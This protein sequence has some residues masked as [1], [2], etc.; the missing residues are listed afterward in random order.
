MN[1]LK[2][3]L[4]SLLLIAAMVMTLVTP[5]IAAENSGS[6]LRKISATPV[7]DQ[8]N[9][10]VI[11]QVDEA[12]EE[13]PQYEDTDIV[14]VSIVLEDDATLQ[15]GFSSINV[16][17][18]EQAQLY[19]TELEREQKTVLSVIEH[20]VLGNRPLDVVWNLTLAANLISANVEYGMIDKI[21]AVSGVKEV[22]LENRYEPMVVSGG[23]EA[24]DPAMATSNLMSG[25]VEAWTNGYTGA[26]SRIA[27]ID[28]GIDL[29]HQSFASAAFD[30][31]LSVNAAA[32]GMTEEAYLEYLDLLDQAEV[33]AVLDQLNV[34]VSAEYTY[35]GTKIPFA[36]NY[37]DENYRVTHDYDDNGE[38]G[39]HVAGIAAAGSYIKQNGEFVDA[40]E[41]V[42][43][44]GVAP[45]AQLLIMKVF[46]E[47][48]GAYDSDYMAAI[49]DAIILGADSVNLSLGSGG[50][51]FSFNRTYQNL[52]A[53]LQET[54]TVVSMSAGNSYS[55]PEHTD[56]GS[57]YVEDVSFDMSGS[58]GSYS[59]ALAV[60]SVDSTSYNSDG[61]YTPPAY[62]TMSDFSSW[63]THGS[64]ELK[65]E[66]TAPGGDIYSVDGI[67]GDGKQYETM[68]GTSMAAPQVAGMAAV[69]AEYIRDN[70]LNETTGL[71]TRQLATSLLMSTAMPLVEKYSE[72]YYSLL[73]QGSGMAVV[74]DAV[75]AD[76]YIM[77]G[78]DAT[79]YA[80]DGK[81][82]AEL[83]EDA[84]KTGVY[85]FSFTINNLSDV[86]K[87]Y[88]LRADLFT[89]AIYREYLDYDT[90][91]LSAEVV[92]TVDGV[93]YVPAVEAFNCDLNEDGVTDAADAKVIL[94]AVLDGT[95]AEL[96]SIADVN[97][98]GTVD[99]YDAHLILANLISGTVVLE[100]NA[101]VEVN[102]TATLTDAQKAELDASYPNGAYV[103]GFIFVESADGADVDHSIP[104]LAFYGSW[105]DASM[106]GV[107]YSDTLYGDEREPY[108]GS[109]LNNNLVVKNGVG[110]S[111]LVTGNP[112]M[113]E[114]SYPEGRIAI[115]SE[116]LMTQYKLSLIRNAVAMRLQ[117]TDAEGTE[118]YNSGI[119]TYVS[120]AYYYVNGGAWRNTDHTY[121]LNLTP[122]AIGAEE[123]DVIKVA[124]T[125]VPEYYALGQ[126]MTNE[127]MDKL[128]AEVMGKGAVLSTT[129]TVDNTAPDITGVWLD[130]E[131][132]ELVVECSDNNYIAVVALTSR[133]GSEIYTMDLPEQTEAGKTITHRIA[134]NGVSGSSECLLMVG[135]YAQNEET[136]KLVLDL[137]AGGGSGEGDTPAIPADASVYA[138]STTDNAWHSIDFTSLTSNGFKVGGKVA[139]SSIVVDAA[140][141]VD[142]YIFVVDA[143]NT[144]YVAKQSAPNNLTVVADLAA[145]TD[146]K[147]MAFN[148]A[149]NQMYVLGSDNTVYTM[150]LYTGE[151]TKQF[152]VSILLPGKSS[153][154][155]SCF[156]LYGMTI[157]TEG[158]FIMANHGGDGYEFAN[159]YFKFAPE[160]IVDGAVTDLNPVMYAPYSWSTPS[161]NYVSGY[162]DN[163]I[164]LTYDHANDRLYY[165]SW[166]RYNLNT[167]CILNLDGSSVGSYSAKTAGDYASQSVSAMYSLNTATGIIQPSQEAVFLRLSMAEKKMTPGDTAKLSY[168]IGP[169]N[170]GN[171]A[172]TWTSSDESVAA[173]ENGVVTAVA[174]GSATITATTVAA[175]NLTATCQILV[176]EPDPLPENVNL[177][178]LIYGADSQT[179]WST[180]GTADSENWQTVYG[181]SNYYYGGVLLDNAILVHD[182]SA[183]YAVDPD[184]FE[185]TYLTGISSSYYWNDG[186]AAPAVDGYF[187]VVVVPHMDGT[188][189][190]L[191]DAYEGTVSFFDLSAT[192]TADPMAN[193][194]LYAADT[195][196]GYPA[197]RYY[198]LT[199]G[200]NIY[201]FVVMAGEEEY[202]VAYTLISESGLEQAGVSA[203]LDGPSSSMIYDEE[204]GYLFLTSYVDA[205]VAY[206][207]AIWPATGTV[208]NLG[209]FGE[210]V[211]P[212]NSL[213]SYVGI[214]ELTLRVKESDVTIYEGD[215][216]ATK[217][218]VLP[219][220]L[221][222]SVTCVSSDT[223]VVTV[224]NN[225]VLTGVAPGT[226]TITV[227]TNETDA[228]GA[229]TATINVTVL[230]TLEENFKVNGFVETTMDRWYWSTLDASDLSSYEILHESGARVIAG[231]VH[232]EKLYVNDGTVSWFWGII[233]IGYAL[234]ID[235]KNDWDINAGAMMDYGYLPADLASLPDLNVTYVDENGE[236]VTVVAPGTALHSTAS[237]PLILM[238]FE[239]GSA[240]G[241]D[242]AEDLGGNLGG[243]AYIGKVTL[244]DEAGVE[245]EA[246]SYYFLTDNGLLYN[247]YIYATY[248][249]E[250]EEDDD[251][252]DYS[253]LYEVIADTGLSFADYTDMSMVIINDGTNFGLAVAYSHD[254]YYIN[255][256]GELY[257]GKVG[258]IAGA[259]ALSALYT[260]AQLGLGEES[261]EETN[262]VKAVTVSGKA[263][264]AKAYSYRKIGKMQRSYL[265]L[266]LSNGA[267]GSL[268]AVSADLNKVQ[269]ETS[270]DTDTVRVVLSEDVA[271]TNGM[272]TVTY[273]PAVLTFAGVYSNIQTNDYR[274]DEV[275]GVVTFDY[276]A[277]RAI[278]AGKTLAE[279]EFNHAADEFV[280]TT[281][282]VETEQRNDEA[283]ITDEA[284]VI[285]INHHVE[286]V[287]AWELVTEPTT[288]SEGLIH[289]VCDC[290]LE[291]CEM[292]VVLP[293]LNDVDYD[294]E[295]VNAPAP[296][297]AGKAIYTWKNTAYGTWIFEVELPALPVAPVD[298]TPSPAPVK[299]AWQ[300]PYKDVNTGHWFYDAVKYVSVNG[301]MNGI[302]ADEFGP[303]LSTTRAMIVT[304]LWRLEG[305]PAANYTMSFTDVAS[306]TWYTEAVRWA[307]SEGIVNGIS[308][309]QFAPNKAITREQLVT[310][311]YRYAMYK[312]MDV[313]VGEDTN[314]LSYNDAFD[315]AEYA[316][317]AMQWAC[318]EGLVNGDNGNLMPKGNATRA[319]VATILMRFCENVQ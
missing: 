272:I 299:P 157:D 64:L 221:N 188:H 309:D 107:S 29:N 205:N 183:V 110:E 100:G 265:T 244:T 71:T 13:A 301:L 279:I 295:V 149:D 165:F 11:G 255:L 235:P 166:G 317:P 81:I 14:R 26:G 220:A 35:R 89:Q 72:S 144:L 192:F 278:A 124:V 298:P 224:D 79:A 246:A 40:F 226:A 206:L 4:L 42:Q 202:D 114:D 240:S 236:T 5:A 196:D 58:P 77:M 243:L 87:Y 145:V 84:D 131:T 105:S 270:V 97:A 239:G 101:S 16:A 194:A 143:A 148:M 7:E 257:A 47:N 104:M 169:W 232:D 119:S 177:Q 197:Y 314:I 302:A 204:S 191:I 12:S 264:E 294:Y 179:Y 120:G 34:T 122:A 141:Y 312:G 313:S 116:D 91:A 285:E 92:F 55:W 250:A 57:L 61:T 152:T 75:A 181:P 44:K 137:E 277:S 300:N 273:D 248:N 102:V 22:V 95:T 289:G 186:A 18:N 147:D 269:G 106:F 254:L 151:L 199:E 51:G 214:T 23:N 96:A 303:N 292:D 201:D 109:E 76:S 32:E 49:E 10:P 216:Y 132:N 1:N 170:L 108:F 227:T 229:R 262:A 271:V 213:Y 127:L 115:R 30:Y 223:S 159:T 28:T 266:D 36:Y 172:V 284:T 123:G 178:G 225:G 134:L 3:R 140:E 190:G 111:Y 316:I 153:A 133:D 215:E 280:E 263:I 161:A 27:V 117:I 17:E 168:E 88:T 21:A 69:M 20:A 304:I 41:T 286:H 217:I 175:P 238:D 305:E 70:G 37:I 247:A 112:Y 187:D 45:D 154:T 208:T 203:V 25:A 291:G 281:I 63:G 282:T 180:F 251:L 59:N 39:S 171:T 146:V 2:K 46:G 158:N 163:G 189:L 48:G 155:E 209:H 245:R 43:V 275:N 24:D 267:S 66:I 195:V 160:E 234:E 283:E 80:A 211:W 241:W 174:K 318:G 94:A 33:E 259:N 139:S 198:V 86:E 308:A 125:A 242:V 67:I 103:E 319:Q 82:K 135:D 210:G 228:N 253:V 38:H 276:A 113:Q 68:S 62:Y 293:A 307:A 193:I 164:S 207:Y 90:T 167:F 126:T 173:V 65:P 9:L 150:N 296:G 252:F 121:T 268:N 52:L 287:Y 78:E 233:P 311:L 93:T 56:P 230:A 156:K 258:A 74:G 184:T 54:E 130:E 218:T 310:I 118:L 212:V 142:G 222:G 8:V 138:F 98:D 237:G 15:A 297:K 249:A 256:N 31:S 176:Q 99:T 128:V 73:K 85:A 315:V 182:G 50:P 185:A 200:G 83:G 60:A 260:D 19:R 306:G 288:E 129:L 53:S 274:V 136:L 231:G 219:L 290:G 162:T 261:G 6:S